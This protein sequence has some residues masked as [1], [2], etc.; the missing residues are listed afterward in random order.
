MKLK[1]NDLVKITAGKDKGRTG[2]IDRVLPHSAQVVVKG[3]NL[4]QRRLKKEGEKG[5]T[6]TLERPLPL[7]NVALICPQC[8]QP[9]R[10]G[11]EVGQ[12]GQKQRICRKC[13]RIIT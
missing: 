12:T 1:L 2:K 7:A 9:T 11:Y 4:Y 13:D 3:I 10:V 8:H 6:I 5:S